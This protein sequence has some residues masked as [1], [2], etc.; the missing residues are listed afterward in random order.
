MTNRDKNI[1]NNFL[2]LTGLDKETSSKEDLIMRKLEEIAELLPKEKKI[3]IF[4]LEDDI[5]NLVDLVKWTYMDY[6]AKLNEITE[7]HNLD[8][9]PKVAEEITREA[10][11]ENNKTKV[12]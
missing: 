7:E 6:G 12:A 1:V 11:E 5:S 3:E 4:R 8:W 10:S 9:T 2:R